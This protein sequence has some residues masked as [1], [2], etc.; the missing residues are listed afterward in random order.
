MLFMHRS[1][2]TDTPT[3]YTLISAEEIENPD[4]FYEDYGVEADS[5]DPWALARRVRIGVSS[6]YE[7]KSGH[8]YQG[9]LVSALFVPEHAGSCFS[10]D[11]VVDPQHQAKGLGSALVDMAIAIYESYKSYADMINPYEDVDDDSEDM[12]DDSEDI[13]YDYCVHVVNPHMKTILERKG[14]VVYE[15]GHNETEW[16]M[17]PL[18]SN[19]KVFH[20]GSVETTQLETCWMAHAGANQQEGVGIYFT[21]DMTI[22]Q[23]YGRFVVETDIDLNDFIDSRSIVEDHFSL[24]DIVKVFALMNDKLWETDE[25]YYFVTNYIV[26][27]DKRKLTPKELRALAAPFMKTEVRLFQNEIADVNVEL[28]V[29]A[30][31]TFLKKKGT[32]QWQTP[33]ILFVAII[34]PTVQVSKVKAP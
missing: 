26:V 29:S 1:N 22:A 30:W 21:N 12:D 9:K 2:P 4:D 14:F 31:N 5:I 34:D 6:R 24:T 15:T 20:G 27:Y 18:R 17:R 16:L 3:E 28:F 7:F 23:R 19:P 25:F 11:I 33:D 13:G 8:L 10:F 32:Y